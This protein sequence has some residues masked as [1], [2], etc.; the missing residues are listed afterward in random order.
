[1]HC[2]SYVTVVTAECEKYLMGKRRRSLILK[3]RQRTGTKIQQLG[4][5][6][7]TRQREVRYVCPEKQ[8]TEVSATEVRRWPKERTESRREIYK[9]DRK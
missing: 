2:T 5:T 6:G 8:R 9:R 7:S 1:M 3:C 4:E